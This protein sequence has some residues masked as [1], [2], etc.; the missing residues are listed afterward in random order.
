[1][2]R[3]CGIIFLNK[4]EHGPKWGSKK[5]AKYMNCSLNIVQ[6]WIKRYEFTGSVQDHSGRARKRKFS[7]VEVR[8]FVAIADEKETTEN[9]EL[10]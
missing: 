4:H 7:E 5:I 9:V 6:H 3:H 2:K 10:Y 1:M 8:K